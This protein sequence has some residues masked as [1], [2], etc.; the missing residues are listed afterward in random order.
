MERFLRDDV[1]ER[2]HNAN[3]EPEEALFHFCCPPSGDSFHSAQATRSD[4]Y[5]NIVITEL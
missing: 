2:D 5:P 3:H 4:G 1:I